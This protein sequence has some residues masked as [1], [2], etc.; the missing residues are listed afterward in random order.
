MRKIASH[1]FTL[2]IAAALA[3]VIIVSDRGALA[4]MET[5]KGAG[6]IKIR[7]QERS[8]PFPDARLKI[9]SPKD[10]E[11]LSDP[12][13]SITLELEGF[14]TQVQTEGADAK[15]LA[16]SAKG[17]HVHVIIDNGPYKACYDPSKP[18]PLGKLGPGTHVVRAFPSRSYHESVK[19]DG[20]FAI[21]TFHVRKA[22]MPPV[23]ADQPLLTYSRPKGE[24]S[25]DGAR[26]I[27]VDFYLSHVELGSEGNKVQLTVDGTQKMLTRWTPYYVEGLGD[28]EHLFSLT[29]VDKEGAPL[30][31]AYNS[32]ERKI[33]V[34][35]A[36]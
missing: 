6:E 13:V 24:Y 3:A 31:G 16:N 2:A 32:T 36:P 9:V 18:F 28:G 1:G 29:L 33:I 12:N 8:S 20:A 25:G 15:G 35:D 17:Q 5:G 23:K 19:T 7:S 34:K 22:G 21:V 27:M 26:K 11:T 30:P 14:E 4:G 10:G